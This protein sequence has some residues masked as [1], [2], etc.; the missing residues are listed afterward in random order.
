MGLDRGRDVSLVVGFDL[1]GIDTNCCQQSADDS[2]KPAKN[3]VYC[4]PAFKPKTYGS[5]YYVL[6]YVIH[7]Y[8]DK[9][10]L[11]LVLVSA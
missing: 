6:H 8:I 3:G 4:V 2:F 5:T 10:F 11:L 1:V 9:L 7:L